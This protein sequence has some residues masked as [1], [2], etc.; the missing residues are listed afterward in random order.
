MLRLILQQCCAIQQEFAYLDFRHEQFITENLFGGNLE[1]QW[2]RAVPLVYQILDIKEQFA[3]G[4]SLLDYV[5][6][7]ALSQFGFFARVLDKKGVEGK[8]KWIEEN[9]RPTMER[10]ILSTIAP[11]DTLRRAIDT[12]VLE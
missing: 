8:E 5:T 9:G 11:S 1:A 2:D 10:L 7:Y 6:T 4:I 3:A 12:H